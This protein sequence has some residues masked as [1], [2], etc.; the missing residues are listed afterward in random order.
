AEIRVGDIPDVDVRANDLLSTVF[1]NLLN[2]SVQHNDKPTPRV[3]VSAEIDNVGGRII[4]CVADNG[5]GI[6]DGRKQEVFGKGEKGLES[7][8]T[9]V[10]LYLVNTLVESYGGDVWVEDNPDAPDGEGT[11]FV[12][13]LQAADKY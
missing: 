4:V 3:E 1:R 6:P 13:E 12:V 10:G 11:V 8:G 7:E 5:P 2:N 9:G